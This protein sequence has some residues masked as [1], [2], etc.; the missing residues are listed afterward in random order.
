MRKLRLKVVVQINATAGSEGN[1]QFS[2]VDDIP[3]NLN[4]MIKAI[5]VEELGVHTDK[6]SVKNFQ[7]FMINILM[8]KKEDAF[9]I[10]LLIL[11]GINHFKQHRD[12]TKA[13]KLMFKD[14]VNGSISLKQMIPVDRNTY[15][16]IICKTYDII[17][18]QSYQKIQ[19][20]QLAWYQYTIQEE[21][22][23]YDESRET[24]QSQGQIQEDD[25]ESTNSLL[26]CSSTPPNKSLSNLNQILKIVS[27]ANLDM[28]LNGVLSLYG[29]K[30]T[31]SSIELFLK[32]LRFANIDLG[33]MSESQSRLVQEIKFFQEAHKRFTYMIL[34]DNVQY[35]ELLADPS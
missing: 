18:F 14:Q 4:E 7:I 20:M 10:Y 11:Q 6:Q 29:V 31:E 9:N 27:P 15:L 23:S 28:I 33:S 21:S 34:D 32:K 2:A 8:E 22:Q 16:K 3:K 26:D 25:N 17:L 19:L 30:K 1:D 5:I 35:K 24:G 13:I 12:H